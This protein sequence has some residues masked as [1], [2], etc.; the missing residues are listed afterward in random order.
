MRLFLCVLPDGSLQ[1]V[2]NLQLC[3]Q[4]V[5]H[6]VIQLPV[7]DSR[8]AKIFRPRLS[9]ALRRWYQEFF[10]LLPAEASE[11]CSLFLLAVEAGQNDDWGV[12]PLGVGDI[13]DPT[14]RERLQNLD[15]Q[16]SRAFQTILGVFDQ[17]GGK[18]PKSS[19]VKVR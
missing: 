12:P 2:F 8:W 13:N 5:H 10:R 1:I 14:L 4:A 19:L 7:A 3:K 9:A 16:D 17:F 18:H 15:R 6:E 11:L